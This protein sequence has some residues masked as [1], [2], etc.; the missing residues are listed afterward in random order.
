MMEH[1]YNLIGR[2]GQAIPVGGDAIKSLLFAGEIIH[3][4]SSHVGRDGW[5]TH[6]FKFRDEVIR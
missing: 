6:Y 4:Y 1:R 5:M 3:D 2:K